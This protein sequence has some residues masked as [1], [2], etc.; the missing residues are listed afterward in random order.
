MVSVS[1]SACTDDL[2][3]VTLRFRDAKLDDV[4]VIAGLQN[5]ASGA[6]TDRFGEGPWSGL[7]SERGVELSLRHSRVRVGRMDRKVVTVLRLATKKPW[8]IDVTYFTPVRL[9]LYLTGM[10]VSVAHMGQ[11]FGREALDDAAKVAR[12]WPADAIRLDAYHGAGGAGGFY[13]KCGY[14][15]RGDVSYKGTP[16][17]YYE[18]L[19][20]TKAGHVETRKPAP[21]PV[22]PGV[23]VLKH[24]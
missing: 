10:A 24:G 22:R 7:T 1:L 19:L 4:P 17:L 13:K 2:C 18:L 3:C 16:L 23:G 14:A 20:A 12:D 9:P 5:A 21:I 8:A 15:W 11:G 6:L